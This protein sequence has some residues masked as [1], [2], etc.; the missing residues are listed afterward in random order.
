MM[1]IY[2]FYYYFLGTTCRLSRYPLKQKLIIREPIHSVLRISLTYEQGCDYG[3]PYVTEKMAR[4][5]LQIKEEN[6]S[7]FSR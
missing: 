4:C 3:R 6:A 1:I 5:S 7:K 2:F